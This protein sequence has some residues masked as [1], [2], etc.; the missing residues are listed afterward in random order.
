MTHF[1][2]HYGSPTSESYFYNMK[3][4]HAQHH[5]SHHDQGEL[6]LYNNNTY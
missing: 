5:F 2:I 3:R 1:Y 6:V 4:Y